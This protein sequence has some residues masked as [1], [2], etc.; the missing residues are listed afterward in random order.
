MA[1]K[2]EKL[3]ETNITINMTDKYNAK[4]NSCFKCNLCKFD[5]NTHT[6]V[7]DHDHLTGKF[8]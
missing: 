4:H 5:V 7:R 8:R 3:L 1:E 6:R 2:I